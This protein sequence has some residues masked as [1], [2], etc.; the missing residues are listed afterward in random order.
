MAANKVDV[1][2]PRLPQNIFLSR[3][4]PASPFQGGAA[5][6]VVAT[7]RPH[8]QLL[9]KD[10]RARLPL[11]VINDIMPEQQRNLQKK[12]KLKRNS[13][14]YNDYGA[15]PKFA[16]ATPAPQA[17]IQQSGQDLPQLSPRASGRADS[18]ERREGSGE[19]RSIVTKVS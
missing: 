1:R 8:I 19:P 10:E 13:M 16:L 14:M 15:P 5:A 2:T 4:M 11:C 7:P 6:S 3:E 9:L 17:T 18:A 12:M